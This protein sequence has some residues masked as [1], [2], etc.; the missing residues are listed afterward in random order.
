[1]KLKLEQLSKQLGQ[2]LSPLYFISG[3]ESLLVQEASDS[4][5]RAARH[6]G[7]VERE[8]FHLD[9]ANASW[10]DI[11]QEANSL[12]LF[13]D[14]KVIEVRCKS[15][16]LG[17]KGSKAILQYL[18]DPNADVVLLITTPK[19]EAAQNKS[20]WL[21]GIEEKGQH[22]PVWPIERT[23]LPKWIHARLRQNDLSAEP[24]AI[25]FLADNVE[26]NL[27]AAKQE[28]DKLSLLLDES[29]RE[30][31]I[32]IDTMTE[33]ISSS[34]RYTVFN[35]VDR[36]LAGDL[37]HCLRT[38]NGL[39]TEGAEPTLILWSLTREIRSLHKLSSLQRQ[40]KSQDQAMRELRIFSNRQRL[41]QAAAGRLSF[42]KL[43]ALLRKAR[44]IDQSIKGLNSH[45]SWQGLEQLCLQMCKPPTRAHAH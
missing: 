41:I 26:G 43:E 36:C 20:K 27:L 5:R 40:G 23:Q 16:K 30:A 45:S 32:S 4:I 8:L 44:Q 38:L 29:Q 34:S 9:T 13:S 2:N 7:F 6:Q 35:L 25:E 37:A 17:D 12:S 42:A 28:I 22:I 3:D 21:K 10:D 1:M 14:K 19:L 24:D 33:L 39:K 11:L 18:S 31:P 15:N